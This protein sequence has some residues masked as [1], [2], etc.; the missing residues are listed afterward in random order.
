MAVS[1]GISIS[2]VIFGHENEIFED[3]GC[4]FLYSFQ[5]RSR[6][7]EKV[8]VR[9]WEYGKRAIEVQGYISGQNLV[10]WAIT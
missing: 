1:G 6:A 7:L 2:I 8:K 10:C 4:T 9:M 3:T 5:L